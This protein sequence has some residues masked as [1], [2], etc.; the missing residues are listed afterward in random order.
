[1]MAIRRKGFKLKSSCIIN[2][3]ISIMDYAFDVYLEPSIDNQDAAGMGRSFIYDDRR[4]F[5][6]TYVFLKSFGLIFYVTTLTQCANPLIYIIM[7][8]FM[9]LSTA[10]SARY[11]YRHY[12]RYGSVFTSIREYLE[13]KAGLWPKTRF[14]F[15]TT[16]FALKIWYFIYE[17]PPWFDFSSP[18]EVGKSVFM[19][20]ILLLLSM[21]IISCIFVS[22]ICCCACY[23]NTVPTNSAVSSDTIVS[24][25]I[26]SYD[27]PIQYHVADPPPD[28]ECCICLDT[29]ELS[30]SPLPW[31]ELPC[32]HMFHHECVSRW[33][34]THDTCP[35]CRLNVRGAI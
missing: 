19:I 1:M 11:E 15:S 21:Y 33:L 8:G 14:L 9:C 29:N 3:E 4:F 27:V 22:W 34:I 12:Q 5:S 26:L 18:C 17:F 24:I 13:W 20:H 7:N 28:K 35:V 16:E 10:N 31:A 30:S 23:P 25:R 6:K 32:K 2:Y